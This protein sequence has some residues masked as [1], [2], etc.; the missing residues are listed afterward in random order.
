[1]VSIKCYTKK[2]YNLDIERVNM[3]TFRIVAMEMV[4]DTDGLEVRK[5]KAQAFV[6]KDE[7]QALCY[8]IK[9]CS[10]IRLYGGCV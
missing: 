10:D 5:P 6:S 1:M 9:T 7:L 8:A 4:I 2:D 3:L